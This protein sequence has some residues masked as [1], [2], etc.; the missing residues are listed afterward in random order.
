MKKLIVAV[1]A[2]LLAGFVS[3][4][5]QSAETLT[6]EQCL[7]CHGPTFDDLIAK[8][9]QAQ[10]DSGVVNPHKWIPHA[11]DEEKNATECTECHQ[12]HAFPPPKG[13]K[14]EMASLEPCYS[15]HHNYQ[16]KKCSECHN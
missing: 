14:D 5:L 12:Q 15:C 13:Y 11:G 1:L 9:V 8:N 3:F 6:K 7:G 16:F 10:S 4:P 2:L